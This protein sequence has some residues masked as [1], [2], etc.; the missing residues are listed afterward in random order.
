MKVL[1]SITTKRQPQFKS[2]RLNLEPF[3]LFFFALFKSMS[4]DQGKDDNESKKIVGPG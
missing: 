4:R 2:S 1:N 3:S